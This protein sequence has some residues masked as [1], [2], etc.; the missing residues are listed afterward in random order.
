MTLRVIMT[1]LLLCSCFVVSK[2]NMHSNDIMQ[3]LILCA[4]NE[5]QYYSVLNRG[6]SP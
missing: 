3:L 2:I 4:W 6:C 5:Y 1:S